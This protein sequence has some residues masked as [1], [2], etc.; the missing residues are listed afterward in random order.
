MNCKA[1]ADTGVKVSPI[2]LGT[3]KI[4]RDLGV[5]YPNAFT[6]PD[7]QQVLKLLSICREL[8]INLLDTAPAYGNS[9]QRL[10][11]LLKAVERQQWIISSKAGE[12][13][14]PRTGASRY[15]FSERAITASVERSLQRLKTDYLDIVMIHSNG[16]DLQI[17]EQHLA[18]Q[19]LAN[20]K[21][22]GK[23]R[24]IGMSTKTIAGGIAALQQSDC[25]MVTYNLVQREELAVIEYAQQHN[26]GIFIKKAFASGHLQQQPDSD[27][28]LSSLKLIFSQ[29]GVS[30]AVIGTISEK[31]L[32]ANVQ[33]YQ[34]VIDTI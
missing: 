15:D 30:S 32:R 28:I 11:L 5:K 14:D 24:A 26:K 34:Q 33:K 23:V 12:E 27:P 19:T 21:Q 8:G 16:D 10:G 9:E 20:L 1:V 4:G 31:N 18:L 7:D 13:F 2:G 22:Q 17:I 29:P 3:V 25:A 6:I